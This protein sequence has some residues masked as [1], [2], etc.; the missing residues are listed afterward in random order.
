MSSVLIA[1]RRLRDDRA[2]AI[3]VALVVLVTATIFA[4]APRLLDRIGDAAL[5]DTI[6]GAASFDRTL[7]VIEEQPIA[8]GGATDPLAGVDAEGDRLGAR[9]PASIQGIVDERTT[10]VD[11][12]R[13][14]LKAETPDP[15]FVRFRIQPGAEARIHWVAGRAP[16]PT[17]GTTDLPPAPPR[18]GEAPQT[19]AVV[20][21][22]GIAADAVRPIGHGLGETIILQPDQ[23]D[24]LVGAGGDEGFA[25]MKIVGLFTVDD[26]SDPFWAADHGLEHVTYRS[27]G[28]DSLFVDVTA[29]VPPEVYPA[30]GVL[31]P[32]HFIGLRTTWRWF[33]DP[34]T[35]HAA[36]LDPL[37]RDLRRLDTTFPKTGPGTQALQ[38]PALQSGL[39]PL[40]DGHRGR[41]A[42]A[43][44]VLLV[45]AIGPATIA[46]ATLLLVATIAASRRRTAIVLVRGR[47]GT[48]GQLTRAL[49]LEAAVLVIPVSALAIAVTVAVLPPAAPAAT[50]SAGAVPAGAAALG[51]G[52]IRPVIAGAAIVATIMAALLAL[53]GLAGAGRIGPGARAADDAVPGRRSAR[54]T[55]LDVVVIA[56]AAV[57][58]YL[59]RERGVR[60]A[61]STAALATAD[62]LIA[63]VPALAGL[64]VALAAVR[65]VPVPIR[66]LGRLMA[67]GRG[68][69]GML[70]LRRASGSGTM[71]PL[72]VVLLVVASIGAFASTTLVHLQRAGAASGWQTVGAPYRVLSGTGDLPR[73]LDP[74]KLPGVRTSAGDFQ[75][76][77]AFGASRIRVQ[78]NAVDAPAYAALLAGSPTDPGLPAEMLGPAPDALPVIVSSNL[79]ARQDGVKLG[80]RFQIAINGFEFPVRV[81]G[82]RDAFPG[83]PPTTFFAFISRAQILEREP[84]LTLAPAILFLDAPADAGPALAAAV[85]EITPTARVDDRAAIERAFTDS[86]V[87]AAISAGVALALAVAAAYAAV[88]VTAALAI[89]G[90]SRAGETAKLRTLG[91][92]RRQAWLL[93]IVEHGPTVVLAF[94]AGVALG[95]GLFVLLEPGLGLDALVGARVAVPLSADPRQ[96]GLI[97]AVVVAIASVGIGL[98]AWAQRR[99]SAV[100]ALRRGFD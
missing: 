90:A 51:V 81:A 66:L 7:A 21:E 23:R 75:A 73:A 35:L 10:V 13:F 89:A 12:M 42:A 86:P 58:A 71:G 2:A 79:L 65:L 78:V 31:M 61:S 97:L 40:L 64:A 85:A 88:A 60:G 44:A 84:T 8:P 49:L 96:I 19:S 9:F 56:F 26:P 57:G 87:T 16:S 39:L 24:V 80:D 29:L 93:T 95:I 63:A 52:A 48:L 25:A 50:G 3:A 17:T 14:A 77:V 70:A 69:V 6:R 59:L 83:I 91:L 53:T 76:L 68:L 54:R 82:A 72:L 74:A 98:A 38:D 99:G 32:S 94:V 5:Q 34:A 41:W 22:V 33:V 15:T 55:L 11:T 45:V 4:A 92:S 67:A 100:V 43:L 36:D 18:P 20:V 46:I 1:L 47:G 27:L 37:V 28:G 62:P 30:Y